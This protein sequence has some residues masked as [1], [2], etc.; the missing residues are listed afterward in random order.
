MDENGAGKLHNEKIHSLYRSPNVIRVVK[1]KI[2]RWT[3]HVARIKEG[4]S[5][6][7]ILTGEHTVI[8][9]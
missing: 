4:M 5:A 8:N 6:F 2:F 3:G 1:S 9:I 7:K